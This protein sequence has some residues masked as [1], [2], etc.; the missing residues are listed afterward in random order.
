[1]KIS[2]GSETCY[3]TLKALQTAF[4]TRSSPTNTSQYSSVS[5][6]PSKANL[7]QVAKLPQV[8]GNEPD[9]KAPS[10][11]SLFESLPFEIRRHIPSTLDIDGLKRLVQASPIY[12]H[13][14]QLD[15]RLLICQRLEVTLGIM[16][17]EAYTVHKSS[18]MEVSSQR[19]AQGIKDFLAFYHTI[20][21]EVWSLPLHKVLSIEEVTAIVR[22]YCSIVQVFAVFMIV[23]ADVATRVRR[24]LIF[25]E[26][27]RVFAM[28]SIN[29]NVSFLNYMY[30]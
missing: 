5:N 8:P 12:Y 11:H 15:R 20:R 30:P 9:S 2:L 18:S 25:N 29:Y 19:T 6:R 14:Y 3:L 17:A 27:M 13:Q 26:R 24:V 7:P 16:T 10:I 23:R 4:R 22:F 21:S 28:H 1:M